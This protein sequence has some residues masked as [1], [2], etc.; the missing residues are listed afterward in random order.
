MKKKI[1]VVDNHPVI[2]K[3][4]THLLEK[5]GHQVKTAGDGLSAL[6]ILRTSIPHVMFIDLVMP[7]ID[8]EQLCRIIQEM[9]ELKD[10][11]TVILSATIAEK[12]WDFN[13]LGADA[14]IVKGPFDQMAKHVLAAIEQSDRNGSMDASDKIM[15]SKGVFNGR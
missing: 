10:T 7:N 5:H 9:P 1:L 8:G 12:S 2:L 3:Y 11:Y 6:D 14:F 13:E 4:M 15:G